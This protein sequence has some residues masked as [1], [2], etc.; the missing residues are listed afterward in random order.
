MTIDDAAHYSPEQR[1][2]I[3]GAYPEHERQ[4]RAKGIP[5]LGSGRIFPVGRG[6][7][8]LRAVPAAALL[9]A[10]W[11]ARLRL[12]SSFGRGRA[13]LGYGGRCRLCHQSRPRLAADAGRSSTNPQ[14]WPCRSR[15]LDIYSKGL[16]RTNPPA[17]SPSSP[18]RRCSA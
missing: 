5:V 1:A 6:A 13:R 15:P 7:D 2:A 8:R 4:A 12:G 9:A 18:S 14:S 3:I 17:A 10:P 11:G 16:T